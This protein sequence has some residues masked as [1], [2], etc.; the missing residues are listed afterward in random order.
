MKS[1]YTSDIANGLNW[2]GLEHLAAR[3]LRHLGWK[4]IT[5]IG[6]SGDHGGDLLGIH[7][8]KNGISTPWV[9]QVKAVSTGRYVGISAIDEVLKALGI[10]NAKVA[11]VITNGEFISTAKPRQAELS[12]CGYQVKLWNGIFIQ[13]L[14]EN[15][16]DFSAVKKQLRQY[17]QIIVDKAIKI[18][19]EGGRRAYYIVATGLGKT[20]IAAS[21]IQHFWELG[22]RRILVLCHSIELAQQLEEGFWTQISKEVPTHVF[23]SGKAPLTEECISFGLFQTLKGFLS[24]LD[25]QQFDV[26]IVDEVHHIYATEFKNCL[27]H[28]KPKFKIGMTATPWRGDGQNPANIFGEPI[29]TVSLIDG[30]SMGYLAQVDYR[31]FCDNINWSQI[32]YITKKS[33][34]IKDLNKRLFLPQR[35]EAVISKIKTTICEIESPR[36]VIF[37]PSIE[38]SKKFASMLSV[39]GIPCTFVSDIK[40]TER[41]KRLLEF[42][43]GV[44]SAITAV[45]IMNEGI[46]IPDVNILVFLRATHSR[47]IFVQQLGRG[48]RIS[49][50]KE[51][52]IVLDFVSDLRRIAGVVEMNNEWKVKGG[53]SETLYL[54]KGIVSFSDSSIE[55]FINEWILDVA[56]ISDSDDNTRLIF[57]E[58]L[59]ND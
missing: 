56:N 29:A 28:F 51:K 54:T 57:P 12:K 52:V 50:K 4:Y 37:S 1:F 34:T 35:D 43:A 44:Y 41:R 58:G 13:N 24:S 30:M 33:M 46:D 38:H 21:I 32:P 23:F 55:K 36:I 48:L 18:Y 3:I 9:F 42:A 47:R 53:V 31:I 20:V 11:C 39:A 49:E 5:I 10:Y 59:N 17:Q 7:Y 26:I 19:S 16:S 25:P 27:N 45:D 14:I 40:K 15:M 8:D 2:K 22:L 6:G